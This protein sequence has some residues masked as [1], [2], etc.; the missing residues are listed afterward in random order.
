MTAPVLVSP[1]AHRRLPPPITLEM[2]KSRILTMGVPFS[3]A[4]E[5]EVF[6]LQIP[7]NDA[8]RVRL[9]ER[10]AQPARGPRP[11]ARRER[12]NGGE[13]LFEV[14]ADERLHDEEGSAAELGGDVGVGVS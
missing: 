2:P 10:R 1:A 12:A 4:M 14:G 7:M 8:D 6:G 5:E 3:R 11:F 13:V 9:V